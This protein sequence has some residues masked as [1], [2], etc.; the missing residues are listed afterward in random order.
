MTGILGLLVLAA[1]IWALLNIL[2]SKATDGTKILWAL[3]VLVFPIGG[4]IIWYLMGPKK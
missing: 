2:Q 3:V 4:M 1:D